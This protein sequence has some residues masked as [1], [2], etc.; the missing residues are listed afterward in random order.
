MTRIIFSFF[1]CV[2]ALCL[3]SCASLEVLHDPQFGVMSRE[4]LPKFVK[5]V[6]CELVTFYDANRRRLKLYAATVAANPKL[7]AERYSYFPVKDELFGLF[8]VDLKVQDTLGLPASGSSFDRKSNAVANTT[9]IWHLGPNFT[10]QGTYEFQ[11]LFALEQNARLSPASRIQVSYPSNEI[12]PELGGFGC[13]SGIDESTDRD[14]LANHAYPETERF[15]RIWVNGVVPLA[16]WL[17][18]NSAVMSTT[19]LDDLHHA[20]EAIFPAQMY[21]TFTVQVT[22]G[23]DVKFS[24]M[25]PKWSPLAPDISGSVQQTNNLQIFINGDKAQG[26]NGAKAGTTSWLPPKV[27]VAHVIVDN[28]PKQKEGA[29]VESLPPGHGEFANKPLTKRLRRPAV[30]RT[31]QPAPSRPKFLDRGQGSVTAPLGIPIPSPIPQ[32]Q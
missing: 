22:G 13:Y 16:A 32:Q 14:A 3:G 20:D 12:Y 19:L 26:A 11:W 5:S 18:A 31:Q 7:A 6:R 30:P 23:A 24:L 17:Q 27:I 1:N 8:F 10:D 15:N 9:K 21:Y 28:L 4:Q 29:K 2:L 25:S